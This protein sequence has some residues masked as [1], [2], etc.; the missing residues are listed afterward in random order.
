MATRRTNLGSDLRWFA[1]LEH[2]ISTDCGP[3]EHWPDASWR[4][5]PYYLIEIDTEAQMNL[6]FDS[7]KDGLMTLVG[8]TVYAVGINSRYVV[9]KQHPSSD[10]LKFDRAVTNYFV[11]D[12]RTETGAGWRRK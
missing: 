4:H 6:S 3:L 8:P 1:V 9:V 12:R 7:A 2:C 5:D 11:V 10:G